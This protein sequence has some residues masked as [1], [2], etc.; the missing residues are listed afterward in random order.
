MISCTSSCTWRVRL[1]TGSGMRVVEYIRTCCRCASTPVAA[2]LKRSPGLPEIAA[3]TPAKL[4]SLA[5][6]LAGDAVRPQEGE[7]VG[8]DQH[9][10]KGVVPAHA[11]ALLRRPRDALPMLLIERGDLLKRGSIWRGGCWSALRFVTNCIS[12]AG[13]THAGTALSAVAM[14]GGK[15]RSVRPPR[16]QH[17]QQQNKAA[18]RAWSP[19]PTRQRIAYHSR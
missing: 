10:E 9:L 14:I 3:P 7:V 11:D 17:G 13:V 8:L 18:D 15:R 6:T 12:V 4:L 19:T 16:D 5:V 1:A 2:S